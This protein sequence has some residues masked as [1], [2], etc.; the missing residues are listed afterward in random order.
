MKNTYGGAPILGPATLL[1]VA[2]L[3]GCFS[4][5]V[6]CANGTKS[7]NTS[8]LVYIKKHVKILPTFK[9]S[10]DRVASLLEF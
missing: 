2:L 6:N 8:H 1:K 3:H 5:S 4:R 9:K 7:R 10:P